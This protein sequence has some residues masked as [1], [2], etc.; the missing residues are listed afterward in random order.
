MT[1]TGND[2]PRHA[3]HDGSQGSMRGQ[4]MEAVK[5]TLAEFLSVLPATTRFNIVCFGSDFE[6]YKDASVPSIKK[7][8]RAAKVTQ[9]ACGVGGC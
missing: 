5:A 2:H 6:M 8:L 9:S 4:R 3:H 7:N 1:S